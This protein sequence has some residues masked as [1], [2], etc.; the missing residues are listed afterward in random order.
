[1]KQALNFVYN[2]LMVNNASTFNKPEKLHN[3]SRKIFFDLQN[4]KSKQIKWTFVDIYALKS[5]H[6][7]INFFEKS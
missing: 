1:V 4:N 2:N 6:F 7:F 3:C 5:L